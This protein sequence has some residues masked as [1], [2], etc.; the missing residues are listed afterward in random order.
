MHLRRWFLLNYNGPTTESFNLNLIPQRLTSVVFNQT[1][2]EIKG[3]H[4]TPKK[5]KRKANVKNPNPPH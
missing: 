3:Q 1:T 4:P 5:N 2:V